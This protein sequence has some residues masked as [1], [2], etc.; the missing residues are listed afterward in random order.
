MACQVSIRATC[1][2][3]HSPTMNTLLVKQ[4]KGSCGCAFTLE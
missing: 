3:L 2:Q 1:Q 4:T